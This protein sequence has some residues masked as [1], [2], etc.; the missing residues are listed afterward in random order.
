MDSKQELGQRLLV[1]TTKLLYIEDGMQGTQ[2]YIA[3]LNTKQWIL[4]FW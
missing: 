3:L 2:S 4:N 1:G